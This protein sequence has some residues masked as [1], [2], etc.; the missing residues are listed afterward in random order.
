MARRNV[1]QFHTPEFNA[2]KGMYTLMLIALDNGYI[3]PH[4][5]AIRFTFI[6]TCKQANCTDPTLLI[7]GRS[8]QVITVSHCLLVMA[9]WEVVPTTLCFD[10]LVSASV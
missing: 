3:R 8:C 4:S 2:N 7:P 6:T 9:A 5:T 10:Q 1:I